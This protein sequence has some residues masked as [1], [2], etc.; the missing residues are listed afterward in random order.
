MPALSTIARAVGTLTLAANPADGETVV[1]GGQTYTFETGALDAAGKVKVGADAAAS[2]VNLKA[3][4]NLEAGAGTLY[5]SGTVLN[6]HVRARATTATTLVVESKVPGAI[7]N[8]IATTETLVAGG[9]QWGA[10]TLASGS[11]SIATAISEIRARGQLNSDVL[12]ALDT[13]DGSSAGEA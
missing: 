5:D 13:L 11:G 3:A 12:Q 6:P 10:A 7:G 2:L 4:I 8:L 9:S 1:V